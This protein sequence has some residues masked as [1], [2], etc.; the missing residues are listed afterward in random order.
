MAAVA[1]GALPE[2]VAVVR[3]KG[4]VTTKLSMLRYSSIGRNLRRVVPSSRGVAAVQRR[5]A[6]PEVVELCV[7]TVSFRMSSVRDR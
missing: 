4:K 1:P 3:V 7:G 5:Q 2:R 6:L